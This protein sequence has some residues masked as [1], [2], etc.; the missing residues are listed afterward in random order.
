MKKIEVLSLI[1]FCL[2][3]ISFF[4]GF[5]N[6]DVAWNLKDWEYETKN[7]REI[8]RKDVYEVGTNQTFISVILFLLSFITDKLIYIEKK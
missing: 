2:G 4:L 7:N 6:I 5:H 3:L 1:F 8:F